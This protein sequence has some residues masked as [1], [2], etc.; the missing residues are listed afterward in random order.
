MLQPARAILDSI[1]DYW[2][3]SVTTAHVAVTSNLLLQRTKVRRCAKERAGVEVAI[4]WSY[5]R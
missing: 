2:A 5:S 3:V 4:V 1:H